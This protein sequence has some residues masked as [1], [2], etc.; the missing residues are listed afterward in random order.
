MTLPVRNAR[1]RLSQ[2]T[3]FWREVGHGNLTLVLLHG[4]WSDS[5]QWLPLMTELGR[6]FHCLA[7][8]LIGFG[9]SSQ[10]PKLPYSIALEVDCLAEYLEA[11]RLQ[12]VYF[13][14]DA[15]GA[16]VATRYALRY[17]ERV[18]G[19]ILIAP[20][21]VSP[22]TLTGRWNLH[23]L[24]AG[25]FSVVAWAIRLIAPIARWLGQAK[26]VAQWHHLRHRL[27]AFPAACRLLF[28]RRQAELQAELLDGQL[29]YLNAPL[30]LLR[31]QQDSPTAQTL[32]DAY[33]NAVP[34]GQ[35]VE[36]ATNLDQ[37]ALMAEN[38]ALAI[39]PLIKQTLKT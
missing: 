38:L 26:W 25:R 4:T 32:S 16:W 3:L 39:A 18:Q 27:L 35:G 31:G 24:L 8:D 2:G 34:H 12:S 5:S 28:K 22:P 36:V 6:D 14:A 19:L 23:R 9:E 20:E 29:P 15:L 11:L 33:L 7:P 30:Y 10:S 13:I 21:G 37:S 1:I 17:P